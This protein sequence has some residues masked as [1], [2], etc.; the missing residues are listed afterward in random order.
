MKK[1]SIILLLVCA[2]SAKSQEL[3]T[4]TSAYVIDKDVQGDI[5]ESDIHRTQ[6]E[7]IHLLQ[8]YPVLNEMAVFNR[9]KK[10]SL[11][12]KSLVLETEE[13]KSWLILHLRNGLTYKIKKRDQ[14][15][16]SL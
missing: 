1:I 6:D 16:V 14:I 13:N 12:N 4:Y 3:P 7:V 2:L 5:K 8:H 11:I 15:L 10:Y 9:H